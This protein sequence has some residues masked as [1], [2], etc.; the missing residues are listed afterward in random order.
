MLWPI[1]FSVFAIEGHAG[2]QECPEQVDASAC[3][4]D[5]GLLVTFSLFVLAGVVIFVA[6][7]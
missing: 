5:D 1:C 3:K 7:R 4:G 6:A 2:G